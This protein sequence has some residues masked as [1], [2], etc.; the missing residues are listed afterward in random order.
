MNAKELK[1][2]ARLNSLPVSRTAARVLR[3]AKAPSQPDSLYLLSLLAWGL[4][5]VK[6]DVNFQE[7]VQVVH[8]RANELLTQGKVQQAFELLT[9]THEGEAQIGP[10]T[11]SARTP[12]A[13]AEKLM[14]EVVSLAVL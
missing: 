5:K 10:S 6:T 1:V 14:Q 3:E 4:D 9:G 7:K 11:I 13:A 12:E 8:D 2:L